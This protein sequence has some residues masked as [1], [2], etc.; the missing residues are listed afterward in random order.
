M[1]VCV[2]VGGQERG[3]GVRVSGKEDTR[4][5]EIELACVRAM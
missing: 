3:S 1:C 4:G 5:Y 2:W